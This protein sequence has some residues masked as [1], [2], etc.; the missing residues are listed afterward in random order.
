MVFLLKNY[1]YVSRNCVR[2]LVSF[3]LEHD[4][5]IMLHALLDM[6]LQNFLFLCDFIAFALLT[7]I[8]L[9]HNFAVSFTNRARHLDL[10]GHTKTYR[11]DLNSYT[12]PSTVSTWYLLYILPMSFPLTVCAKNI[13]GK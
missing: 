13:L 11:V 8:L 7:P 4:L 3:T 9:T 12:S 1:Y 10:L 6:H 2:S 5:L